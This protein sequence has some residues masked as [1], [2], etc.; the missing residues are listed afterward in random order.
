MPRQ[1]GSAGRAAQGNLAGTRSACR[2]LRVL[3]GLLLAPTACAAP[4]VPAGPEAVPAAAA[5]ATA[6]VRSE[7]AGPTAAI[8]PRDTDW[9][10]QERRADI[11]GGVH[12]LIGVSARSGP[13]FFG[14]GS[15]HG[16][17]PVLAV[18]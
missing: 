7:S 6:S 15:G 17:R 2:H 13:D 12:Y 9:N 11:G 4:A 14:G 10:P 18:E 16:L 8:G 5:A 3:P 1:P